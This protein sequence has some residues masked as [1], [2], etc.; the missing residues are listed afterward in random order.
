M[1]F[2]EIDDTSTGEN[3][4]EKLEGKWDDVKAGNLLLWEPKDPAEYD[5]APG[6]KYIVANGHHRFAF[7]D[8]QGVKAY[9]A[10]VLREADG[11]SVAQARFLAAE[12][13]I[14]DGPRALHLMVGM[15]STPVSSTNASRPSRPKQSRRLRQRMTRHSG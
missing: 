3:K 4:T 7:G 15:T 12:A 9:N 1:Q 11:V 6:Q 13:N 10:Q 14:A 8:R 5:L 2:K